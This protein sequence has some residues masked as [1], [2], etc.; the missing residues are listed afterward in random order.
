MSAI[1]DAHDTLLQGRLTTAD[2]GE[3]PL[4]NPAFR[5]QHHAGASREDLG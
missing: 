3:V 1:R 4:S 5:R 2:V